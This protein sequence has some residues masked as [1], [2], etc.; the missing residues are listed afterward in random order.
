MMRIDMRPWRAF[1]MVAGMAVLFDPLPAIGQAVV[2]L[3]GRDQDMRFT[4]EEVFSV[5][6]MM[7]DEWE[8][9]SRVA[10]V[11]F[12]GTGNLYILDADNGRV[13]KVGLDGRFVA[14]MGRKGEGP[15]EFQMPMGMAVT[16]EGEVAV[17]DVGRRGFTLFNPDGSFDRTVPLGTDPASLS[18]FP[19]G[20]ILPL[21]QGGVV[22]G[23]GGGVRISVG[24]GGP[25]PAPEGRPLTV[26]SLVDGSSRTVYQAWGPPPAAPGGGGTRLSA[27]GI[28][29]RAAGGMPRAFEPGLHVGVLPDGSLAVVDS[30]AYRV[31]VVGPEGSVRRTLVRPVAP[32]QVTRRDQEDEKARRLSQLQASGGPRIVM[33]TD[34]GT[35]SM[36]GG[37]IQRMME[38]QIATLEFAE[39][40]PVVAELGVDWTGTIWIRRAGR[41]V[42][43]DGPIDLLAPE[44]RYLG[45]LPAGE[46]RVPSAFGPDGLAAFVERDELDV[47]RVVVKRLSLG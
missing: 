8:T 33:R 36:R 38:E 44:G 45:T 6:S 5:G 47:P 27:G 42:G 32:R 26:Y 18:S 28:S 10:S 7:G 13:V 37:E 3:Q 12:D 34:Q 19:T 40:I 24:P 17:F 2:D 15:G 22:S 21:P 30:A 14:E 4:A 29:V 23:G 31:K 41:S 35:T 11:A 20:S 1:L 9:F 25:S 46:I 43:E 16:R 39:V